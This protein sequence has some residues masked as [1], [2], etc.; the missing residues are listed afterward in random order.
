MN[1]RHLVSAIVIVKD[2]GIKEET[3]WDVRTYNIEFLLDQLAGGVWLL[4]LHTNFMPKGYIPIHS[5][6]VLVPAMP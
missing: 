6:S 4:L 2:R 3:L 1:V 5:V